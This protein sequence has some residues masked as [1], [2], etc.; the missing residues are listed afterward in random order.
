MFRWC[1]G[2]V[3]L[4]L[5]WLAPRASSACSCGDPGAPLDARNGAAQVFRGQVIAVRETWGS[6][7]PYSFR[8]GLPH[9]LRPDDGVLV[10]FEVA[11][12]W[13]GPLDARRRILTGH[14]GGD[15][16]LGASVGD[17]WLIY[18]H[19]D[20]AV[21]Y[22]NICSRS[23]WTAH[24]S[25]DLSELGAGAEPEPRRAP[26]ALLVPFGVLAL[27]VGLAGYRLVRR[28]DEPSSV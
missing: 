24:A 8:R 19:A 1:I 27:A 15:C 17:D 6:A 21:A 7:L 10:D 25:R 26:L 28:G 14:G 2:L 11:R 5:T 20:G 3:A 22:A 23:T 13:K 18:A 16:G 9:W 4:L 12:V